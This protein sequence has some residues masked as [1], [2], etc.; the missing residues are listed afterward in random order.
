MQRCSGAEDAPRALA[1]MMNWHT[2]WPCLLAA[3]LA[4]GCASRPK[5]NPA[6]MQAA[7]QAAQQRAATEALLQQQLQQQPTVLVRGEVRFPLVPW[8]ED[9]TLSKALIAADYIGARDPRAIS[10]IRQGQTYKVNARRLLQ[11][12][13]DPLLEPWDVVQIERW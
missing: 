6:Q 3:L 12:L 11:G 1:L 13:E 8:T 2:L 5:A 10:I 9:L 4:A 7:M